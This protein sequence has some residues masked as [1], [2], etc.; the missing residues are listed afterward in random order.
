[1]IALT[2]KICGVT[3]QPLFLYVS[4]GCLLIIKG[5]FSYSSAVIVG[6]FTMMLPWLFIVYSFH[7]HSI[8]THQTEN[9]GGLHSATIITQYLFKDNIT[10]CINTIMYEDSISKELVHI[11][12]LNIVSRLLILL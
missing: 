11:L 10:V 9:V 1:M 4:C 2:T 8:L 12:Y 7:K 3:E 6:A 5:Y